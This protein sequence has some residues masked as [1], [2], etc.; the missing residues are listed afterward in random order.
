V[1]P[2]IAKGRMVNAVRAAAA[3]VDGLPRDTMSPESTLGRQGFL[4]PYQM[5]GGVA[6]V[7]LKVL[8]RDFDSEALVSQ[9]RFLEDLAR[10]VEDASPGTRV[11][12][13]VTPQYR[14]MAEGLAREPR[15]VSYASRSFERLGRTA[16]LTT[17]RGGTDGSQLTAR[18]LPTPNLSTGQHTPHS[19][20][21]WACLEEMDLAVRMLIELAQVWAEDPALAG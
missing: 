16:K 19:L 5:H 18:G 2:S 9:A 17:V 21:E 20:L 6:E 7:V 4:H 15:A 3:F 14:N 8:L 1:H 12:I 10:R 11:A 13:D